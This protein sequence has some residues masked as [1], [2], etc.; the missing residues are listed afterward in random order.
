[1]ERIKIKNK[2]DL[3]RLEDYGFNLVETEDG[4]C[5]FKKVYMANDDDDRVC[6]RINESDRIVRITRLDGELDSTL[7]KLISDKLTEIDYKKGKKIR[8]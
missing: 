4:N 2:V 6:Y 7:Y 8:W 5:W 3:K 1:M